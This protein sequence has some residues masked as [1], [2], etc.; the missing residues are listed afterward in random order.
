MSETHVKNQK[1]ISNAKSTPKGTRCVAVVG[2]QSSG[3][4]TLIESM[5]LASETIIKK[6]RVGDGTTVGDNNPEARARQ[7]T[8][9]M[10][11]IR[12]NY[13]G[14]DWVALDCPGAVDLAQD[15]R[16]A[17]MVADAVIVVTDPDADRML[18]LGPILRFLDDHKIP[19]MLFINKLDTT[20]GPV[21]ELLQAAQRQSARPLVLRHIPLVRANK[22]TGYVDLV[23]ERAYHYELDKPSERIPIEK[24]SD[25][26]VPGERRALI[27]KLSDFDDALLEKLLED[28]VPDKNEVYRHL[29]KDLQEDLIVPVFIGAAEH[30]HGV[31]RLMKA[32][33]HE[34]PTADKTAA[35]LGIPEGNLVAQIY[36][37]QYA[38]H[39]GK[40]SLARVWRGTLKDGDTL[41]GVR[42]SNMQDGA[43]PK[44]G[45]AKARNVGAGNVVALGKLDVGRAGT[46]LSEAAALPPAVWPVPPAALYSVAVAAKDRKDDVKLGDALR[47]VCEEDPSLSLHH[48]PETSEM[49]LRGQGDVQLQIAL[50]RVKRKFDLSVE[51]RT[52]Q[53]P[54]RETIRKGVV[55]HARHKRQSG[56]HG[57]F[58]DIKVEI[59]PLP[60]GQGFTFTDAIVGG[61][62]PRNFIPG[63][64]AG[65]RDNIV[66]GPLGFPVVDLNVKLFDGQYHSVDSSDQAFRTAARIAMTEGLPQCEPVLLEPIYEVNIYV[67]SEF[68]SKIQRAVTQHR[69]QILGFDARE[70][71]DGW[72]TI[73]VNM[74]ESEMQ[75]LIIEIRSISQGI[76]TYEAKFSHYQELIGRDAEKVTQGRKQHPGAAH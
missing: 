52:P 34:T 69:V 18:A 73:Q 26:S 37:V 16:Q 44:L 42:I 56:G 40:L 60:R 7:M 35:R 58:A 19:H 38:A 24:F 66:Q 50:E 13:L 72:E 63:V 70:G 49:V 10:T 46:I 2:P 39:V 51:T 15:A 59:K 20:S 5:L 17:M 54:Y 45:K 4:T 3:K 14:D 36:K 30:E 29:T 32:L 12:F 23:A 43:E 31:R 74:P 22:I 33:R 75:N 57:Q 27:E 41:A 61:V 8:T 9:D 71:W 11:P 65:L 1:N 53:V 76:G 25:D 28:V 21:R 64:E 67:P 62:V 47:K 55:Q 48:V 6:G 68:T